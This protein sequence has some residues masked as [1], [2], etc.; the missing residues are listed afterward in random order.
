MIGTNMFISSS[1]Q[2][3]PTYTQRP[4]SDIIFTTA[5]SHNTWPFYVTW[6]TTPP[7][8]RHIKILGHGQN[9]CLTTQNMLNYY[10]KVRPTSERC[11]DNTYI[12]L[13]KNNKKS[14][15]HMPKLYHHYQSIDS[16]TKRTHTLH[17][18]TLAA[19]FQQTQANTSRKATGGSC[20]CSIEWWHCWWP[21]VKPNCPQT[22]WIST[23]ALPFC[24]VEL[25]T[26]NLENMLITAHGWQQIPKK[27]GQ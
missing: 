1:L 4:M 9:G 11:C 20:T 10:S 24:L 23:F 25:K 22:T 19:L 6:L 17:N 16:R 8:S 2:R 15:S 18:T 27:C 12:K 5:A 26:S 7:P 14:V 13:G 21:W 3:P